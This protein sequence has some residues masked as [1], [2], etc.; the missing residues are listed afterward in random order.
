MLNTRSVIF[1]ITVFVCPD[2]RNML[3]GSGSWQEDVERL[4]T[5]QAPL[6]GTLG[7]L[8]PVLSSC[9]QLAC[10]KAEMR[11]SVQA[12]EKLGWQLPQ[13][14]VSATSMDR[15]RAR[16]QGMDWRGSWAGGRVHSEH[17]KGRKW[18]K[19]GWWQEGHRRKPSFGT[20]ER[21]VT[22]EGWP[23]GDVC[24]GGFYNNKK[25]KWNKWLP[26]QL[27]WPGSEIIHQCNQINA[28][29]RFL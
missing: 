27:G 11:W 20:E 1:P 2:Q 22:A 17:Q 13:S 28:M 18:G 15:R 6:W 4:L 10:S 7:G 21:G 26:M 29:L 19:T 3:C 24:L 5:C 8:T 16:A 23:R 9:T 14:L 25:H 12:Q